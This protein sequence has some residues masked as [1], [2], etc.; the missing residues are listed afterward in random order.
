MFHCFF[1][2]G[3]LLCQ[4]KQGFWTIYGITS[5]GEGCGQRYG[6]YSKVPNYSQWIK[7]VIKGQVVRLVK[8]TLSRNVKRDNVKK[9][10]KL[11]DTFPPLTS[12]PVPRRG[13]EAPTIASPKKPVK[14]CSKICSYIIPNRSMQKNESDF[15]SVMF[16]ASPY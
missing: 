15:D 7:S 4:N 6:I 3:P 10:P 8:K 16:S 1:S 5:F 2:G 9:K 14:K 11:D 12:S 13:K